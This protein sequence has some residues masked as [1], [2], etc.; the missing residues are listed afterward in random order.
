MGALADVLHPSK[1]IPAFAVV[2]I[3]AL[4]YHGRSLAAMD[5]RTWVKD[6]VRGPGSL[7]RIMLALFLL[8]N[9]KGLPGFWTVS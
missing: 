3:G 1:V 7:S 4:G 9:I 2:I 6:F 5:L 8:I